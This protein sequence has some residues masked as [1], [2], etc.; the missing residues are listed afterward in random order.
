APACPAVRQVSARWSWAVRL[1]AAA[2]PRTAPTARPAAAAV[3]AP[4]PART[5]AAPA[6][7]GA[8]AGPGGAIR[9]GRA[10]GAAAAVVLA[11]MVGTEPTGSAALLADRAC[12]PSSPQT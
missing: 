2:K 6:R 11:A 7:S 1:V 5:L 12:C 10:G 9:P 8:M 3:A 4:V